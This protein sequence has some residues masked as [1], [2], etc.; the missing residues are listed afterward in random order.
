MIICGHRLCPIR[1]TSV[2]TDLGLKDVEVNADSGEFKENMLSAAMNTKAINSR[3][4]HAWRELG[5]KYIPSLQIYCTRQ[6][7]YSPQH[8]GSPHSSSA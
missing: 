1:F 5:G 4:V 6:G 7:A 2:K 8:T 3:V